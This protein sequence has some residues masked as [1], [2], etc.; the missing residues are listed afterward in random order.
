[1]DSKVVGKI[2]RRTDCSLQCSFG[3]GEKRSFEN[4]FL[5][6]MQFLKQLVKKK[7]IRYETGAEDVEV[8]GEDLVPMDEGKKA[9]LQNIRD[10][11]LYRLKFFFNLFFLLFLKGGKVWKHW[12][13]GSNQQSS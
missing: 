10:L 8:E 9:S 5:K 3:V 2:R 4:F 6:K 11:I 1:M 13:C 7:H 12:S